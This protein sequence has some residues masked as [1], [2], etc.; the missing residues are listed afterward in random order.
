MVYARRT[1]AMRSLLPVVA[2]VLLVVATGCGVGSAQ[3]STGIGAYERGD[4]PAAMNAWNELNGRGW[5]H[6]QNLPGSMADISSRAI[7]SI[8]AKYVGEKKALRVSVLR[9]GG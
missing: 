1:F 5:D 9:Q 2:L 7:Q 8:A 3:I 6:F 4:Y